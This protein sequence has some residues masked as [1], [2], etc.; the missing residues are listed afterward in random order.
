MPKSCRDA[1]IQSDWGILFCDYVVNGLNGFLLWN[2]IIEREIFLSPYTFFFLSSIW[3][4]KMG[5]SLPIF[6]A[7][8]EIIV[9]TSRS[10]PHKWRMF[11]YWGWRSNHSLSFKRVVFASQSFSFASV[12]SFPVPNR[13]TISVIRKISIQADN[14]LYERK[15]SNFNIQWNLVNAPTCMGGSQ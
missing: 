7:R 10:I 14:G 6:S 1:Y 4:T 8:S 3:F 13:F 15:H 5:I 12:A 9:S 11:L 2:N